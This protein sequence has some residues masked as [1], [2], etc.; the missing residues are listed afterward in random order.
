MCYTKKNIKG[1]DSEPIRAEIQV[2]TESPWF[3]GHFPGEPLVPGVAQLAM[4]ADLLGEAL[5]FPVT[6]TG[7]SRVRFKQAIRPAETITVRITPK[8]DP[9]AFSFNIERGA[10]PV[11][12]G[13]IRIAGNAPKKKTTD[14]GTIELRPE[15][16]KES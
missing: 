16:K 10:E 2:P 3:D 4:V 5:G 9:L 14:A 11:C 8:E 15:P 1:G 7:V 13:N 12:S 6:L